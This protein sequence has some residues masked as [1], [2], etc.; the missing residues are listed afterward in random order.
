MAVTYLDQEIESLIQER[1][2]APADWG[3][4]IRPKTQAGA[5]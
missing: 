2:P 5:Q 4:R 3:S 1:K